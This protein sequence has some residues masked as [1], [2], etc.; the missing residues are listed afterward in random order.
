MIMITEHF[1]DPCSIQDPRHT[2]QNYRWLRL[3]DLHYHSPPSRNLQPSEIP[4]KD[5]FQSLTNL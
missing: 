2:A 5:L 3:L 1:R 4:I